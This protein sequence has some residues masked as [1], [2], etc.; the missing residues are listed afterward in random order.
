MGVLE[1]AGDWPVGTVALGVT[2]PRETLDVFGDVDRA[3]PWASVTKPTTAYAILMAVDEEIISLDDP[4]GPKGATVRHL[5]AHAAGLP[6]DGRN[7]IADPASRRMYSNAG[8]EI[9]GELVE[10]RTGIPIADFVAENVFAP[11]GMTSSRLTGSPAAD[12]EGSVIDLLA[13][14]R[15][16]FEPTLISEGLLAEAT[17]VAY[18][19]LEGVLPGFGKQEPNDWGLGFEIRDDKDPHWTGSRN[20]PATFGHFGMSGSFLWVDP[21]AAIAC[22]CLADR[23]FDEWA[24]GAWPRLSDDV[25]EEYGAAQA[26]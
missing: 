11:L 5:L 17:S 14:A 16:L 4:A 22:V 23:D 13:F 25:I 21:K 19:G 6:F 26:D 18:P 15:E 10:D 8:F 9:L 12:G 20:S 3:A 2:S 7:P 24:Q 1:Q